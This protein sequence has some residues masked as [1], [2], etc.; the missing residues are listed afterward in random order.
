MEA[1]NGHIVKNNQGY[2]ISDLHPGTNC[3]I[4]I[5]KKGGKQQQLIVLTR[6]D[7]KNAWILKNAAGKKLFFISRAGLFMKDNELHATDTLASMNIKMLAD[8]GLEVNINGAQVGPHK[9][10]DLFISYQTNLS[11][12]QI[13]CI[14]T[15]QLPLASAQWLV[16]SVKTVYPSTELYH[17]E[18]QKEFS[19]DNPAKIKS[20]KLILYPESDCR[21][22]INDKWCQQPIT[23]GVLNVLDITGYVNK[24]DNVLLMDFPYTTGN[25][26]FAAQVS[27]EY[28][29]TDR[30]DFSTDTSWLAADLYYFPPTYGSKP[31]YPL[32]LATPQVTDARKVFNSPALQGVT[33]WT[34]PVACNYLNGLNNLYLAVKYKGDRISVRSDNKLIADNL[35][36]NTE[37]LMDLKRNGSQQECRDL[38]LEIRPW[39][40]IDK[41]YFDIVPAKTDEGASSIESIRFIPEYKAILNITAKP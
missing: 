41:M 14:Y 26:A 7:G 37:W 28:F 15:Q 12:K 18:F 17:K 9:A 6:E 16:T 30:Y 33:E 39:K 20:A 11:K 19:A 35:N 36:N 25:K 34:V 32:G 5:L 1:S 24:G 23:P 27:I 4:N 10:D 8:P 21:F 29:N 3:V 22:R 13:P 31:V 40:I 38:N 2:V